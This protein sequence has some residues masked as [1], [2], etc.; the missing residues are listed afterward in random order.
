MLRT[1][2]GIIAASTCVVATLAAAYR[3][4]PVTAPSWNPRAAADYL[5]GRMA[6]W[7]RWSTAARDHGT[8]CVSCHTALPY[9]LARP[10]LRATLGERDLP[11]P[12]RRLIE[13]VVKRVWLW[14]ESGSVLP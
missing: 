7:L 12:E 9:A 8:S 13:N 11:A 1:R 4:R 2:I 14:K 3:P 10:A 6:W 5:D